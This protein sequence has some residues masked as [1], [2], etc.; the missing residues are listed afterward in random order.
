MVT[1]DGKLIGLPGLPRFDDPE[2]REKSIL[3]R[4][5]DAPD[6]C[7]RVHFYKLEQKSDP[8]MP[9][10]TAL[11]IDGKEV[12]IKGYIHPASGT[13]DLKQFILVPD[14]GTCCFGG[15]PR[16]TS[17]I[18]VKLTGTKATQY[19]RRKLKLAGKFE[20]SKRIRKKQDIDNLIFYRLTADYMK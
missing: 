4:V 18:E 5:I 7:E 9:T 13:G 1:G 6:N 11:A 8:D 16:S 17:M 19:G 12:F 15:Q 14:L 3:R 2:T 20:I 10:E